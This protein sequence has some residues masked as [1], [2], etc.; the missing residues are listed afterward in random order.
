MATCD[1]GSGCKV[2]CANGCWAIYDPKTCRCDAGCASRITALPSL[3]FA[4]VDDKVDFCVRDIPL[5]DVAMLIDS[6]QPTKIAI[7]AS[8]AYESVTI[9]LKETTIANLIKSLGL[10]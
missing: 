5:V 4:T 3:K 2:T 9:D 1:A 7:P 10:V 8:R 6:I